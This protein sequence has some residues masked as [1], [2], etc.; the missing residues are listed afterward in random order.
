MIPSPPSVVCYGEILWDI[1][2][3]KALPGGAPMNVAY[4]LKKLGIEPALITRIGKD[5]HGEKL[6]ALLAANG[7]TTQYVQQGESYPTG[8]VYASLGAHNEVTYDI[9]QPVAWDYIRW[10]DELAALLAG[11]GYFVYGSLTSRSPVSRDTLYRLLEAARTKVLDINLRPPHFS[12]PHVEHLLS[13]AD[14]LKMNAAEL[15]L[16]AGW[17]GTCEGLEDKMKLLQYRFGI[18]TVIVTR[19]G[20]GALL[21]GQGAVV[22]HDGYKV[23]V[24]DTIGSG[25]AFLAGFLHQ[26]HLGAPAEKA[27]TYAS[28]LGALVASYTGACPRYDTAEVA[29]LMSSY[30]HHTITTI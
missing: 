23:Q 2:P 9:V 13:K 10:E 22:R 5:E 27:L 18:E 16:I 1:L 8:K 6:V 26:L 24:A 7:L 30:F 15:D 3:G 29:A 20:E 28:A 17:Y 11:A 4:H 14:L 12:R 19:G 25:D 21:L